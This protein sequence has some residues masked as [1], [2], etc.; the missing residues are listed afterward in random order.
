MPFAETTRTSTETRKRTSDNYVKF[1]DNYRVILRILNTTA[2]VAWKHW[3]PEANGGRGLMATCP[4]VGS[5]VRPCPIEKMSAGKAKDDAEY[6]ERRARP[7]YIVN[8]L[9]RT[10]HVVCPNCNTTTP[11]KVC[12]S[13]KADVSKEKSFPLNKVKILE[14]G[15]RL[16]NEQLNAVEK[17]QQEELNAEITDYDIVFQTNGSGR[18]RKITAIPQQ[19][20]ELDASVLVDPETGEEQKLFD[21]DALCEPNTVE[22]IEAMLRGAT[23]EE[24]NALRGIV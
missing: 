6:T 1:T 10:P 23:I 21:L 4:N 20:K 7:R 12:Q 19:P 16:F 8:V 17:L 3:I 14:Q 24:L 5:Q 15:P 2:R 22:E 13:C 11:G 9:D 18:D